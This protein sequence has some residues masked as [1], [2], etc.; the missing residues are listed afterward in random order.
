M[1]NTTNV[2]DMQTAIMS[3]MNNHLEVLRSE[4]F[5][6][7]HAL[8]Q[9]DRRRRMYKTDENFAA[10]WRKQTN[11]DICEEKIALLKRMMDRISGMFAVQTPPML[12]SV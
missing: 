8:G 2:S 10:Y 7:E 6:A 5:E 11:C 4:L 9:V 12:T 3:M 1:E